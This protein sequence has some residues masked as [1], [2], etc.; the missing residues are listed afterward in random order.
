MTTY[1]DRSQVWAFRGKEQSINEVC[2]YLL[3]VEH[4]DEVGDEIGDL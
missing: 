4:P 1:Q 2:Q 3:G